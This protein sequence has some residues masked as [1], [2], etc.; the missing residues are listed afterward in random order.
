MAKE[1]R[2]PAARPAEPRAA[3]AGGLQGA[4]NSS[5]RSG[6]WPRRPPAPT[7][8]PRPAAAAFRPPWRRA[9]LPWAGAAAAPAFL[10]SHGLY[11]CHIGKFL[12]LPTARSSYRARCS[13]C[14]PSWAWRAA[15]PAPVGAACRS[16]PSLWP[17]GSMAS[18][19][20]PV[21]APPQVWHPGRPP[22]PR[23]EIWRTRGEPGGRG[24]TSR[25]GGWGQGAW[26]KGW[27]VEGISGPVVAGQRGAL[28]GVGV[29]RGAPAR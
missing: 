28:A 6:R 21:A 23:P 2:S 9:R 19:R 12:Q 17:R 8:R 3:A 4:P 14:A 16:H 29:L 5:P 13:T 15:R 20:P 27:G 10:P 25:G 26:T 22:C 18:Q 24:S 1:P 11:T 7:V